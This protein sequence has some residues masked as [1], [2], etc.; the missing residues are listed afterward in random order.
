MEARLDDPDVLAVLDGY[1]T[2]EFATVGRSGVPI[3]WPTSPLYRPGEGL[4]ITTSIGFPQKAYNVRRNPRVGLLFSDPTGSGLD[5]MPQVLV[6]GLASCPD[7]VVV[8]PAGLEDYWTR[9]YER[10]PAGRSYGANPIGR[11]LMDWYYRRLVIT[12]TPTSVHTRPPLEPSAPLVTDGR[13]RQSASALGQAADRMSAHRSAVLVALDGEGSPWLLRVRPHTDQ[14][15]G[16]FLL[17]VPADEHLVPGP[18]SL[19]CHS[20]DDRLWNLRSFVVTGQ[21]SPEQGRWR[22]TVDRFVAGADSNPLH[23]VRALRNC[24]RTA[25]RYLERRT[26]SPPG[27]EWAEYNAVKDEVVRRETALSR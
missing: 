20:H 25:R 3:A 2:C 23:A 24:Q 27:V 1:R 10:Q 16:S 8:S 18:A 26:Q 19:L 12:I 15:E 21:V 6:Q 22:F 7:T 4:L 11:R 9:L 13:G 14:S 5:T 17:D